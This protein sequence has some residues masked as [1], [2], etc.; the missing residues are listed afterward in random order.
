M[1]K[2]GDLGTVDNGCHPR[3]TG[4]TFDQNPSKT[5]WVNDTLLVKS[6]L[7]KNMSEEEV[8]VVLGNPGDV[9]IHAIQD[10]ITLDFFRDPVMASDGFVY[11]RSAMEQLITRAGESNETLKSP[12]TREPL[13]SVELLSNHT[14]RSL[15]S[16]V[17]EKV[18]AA[19]AGAGKIQKRFRGYRL[20]KAV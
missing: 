18:D 4:V 19:R 12:M 9:I 3:K 14:I 11:E 13:S 8:R 5:V 6:A 7:L 1:G 17:I 15:V 10:P 20:R 16:S 2:K